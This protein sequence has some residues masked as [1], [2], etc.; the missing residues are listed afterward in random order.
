VLS[1]ANPGWQSRVSLALTRS[2]TAC[3]CTTVGCPIHEAVLSLHGWE[4]T[5]SNGRRPGLKRDLRLLPAMEMHLETGSSNLNPALVR[6]TCKGSASQKSPLRKT[7]TQL[8]E[9]FRIY[10]RPALKEHGGEPGSPLGRAPCRKLS[11]ESM[12]FSP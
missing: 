7:F 10:C 4:S 9:H 6:V 11:M 8:L 2:V 3:S 1:K 5:K 12:G